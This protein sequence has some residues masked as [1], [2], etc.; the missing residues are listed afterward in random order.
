MNLVSW[1]VACKSS[2]EDGLQAC[3]DV[4]SAAYPDWS[5]L[6]LSEC[7][8]IASSSHFIKHSRHRVIRHW[9]GDGSH[10]MCFVLRDSL[11][12]LPTRVVPRNRALLL[13]IPLD[14]KSRRSVSLIGLHAPHDD[15]IDFLSDLTFLISSRSSRGKFALCGDWN[16]NFAPSFSDYPF[17]H[18]GFVDSHCSRRDDISSFVSEVGL[19]LHFASRISCLPA[20]NWAESCLTFPFT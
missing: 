13:E 4:A 19:E 6:F 7:D 8:A 18:D 14:S 15:L 17:A 5:V 10:A 12:N 16:V 3:I 20:S 1:N 11:S 9:P 2:S